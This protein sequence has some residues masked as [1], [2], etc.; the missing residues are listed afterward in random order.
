M[1]EAAGLI[2]IEGSFEG[3]TKEN[4]LPDKR[5]AVRPEDAVAAKSS[6]KKA[7]KAAKAKKANGDL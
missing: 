1:H 4:S 3:L 5:S 2:S 7:R 6:K